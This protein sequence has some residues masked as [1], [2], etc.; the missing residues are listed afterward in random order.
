MDPN[1]GAARKAAQ[2]MMQASATYS[3]KDEAK[4]LKSEKPF[5]PKAKRLAL[6]FGVL[7]MALISLPALLEA[8]GTIV[9]IGPWL[10]LLISI[11]ITAAAMATMGFLRDGLV[12][13]IISGVIV[14]F[15]AQVGYGT[16]FSPEE[17]EAGRALLVRSAAPAIT[18]VMLAYFAISLK[19]HLRD[20]HYMIAEGE[21]MQD[22]MTR[23][24]QANVIKKAGGEPVLNE[25]GQVVD[26]NELM[27]RPGFR[28]KKGKTAS[29]TKGTKKRKKPKV[30]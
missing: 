13:N 20:L 15:A 2:Q 22:I 25:K 5:P 7:L 18:L 4:R 6:V 10:T 29:A 28:P 11:P 12:A 27:P 21:S 26:K 14:L 8:T 19:T 23:M 16:T 24:Q 9:N 30:R 17:I 1:S 3:R